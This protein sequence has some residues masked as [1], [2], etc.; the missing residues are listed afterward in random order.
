MGAQGGWG[1]GSGFPGESLAGSS[2]L[3]ARQ[4]HTASLHGSGRSR[5][6]VWLG[7]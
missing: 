2:K 7:L 4:A 6:L 3:L 5:G 1:G